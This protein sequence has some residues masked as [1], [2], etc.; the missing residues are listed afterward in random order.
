MKIM[1]NNQK[2]DQILS[3][4][5]VLLE[6]LENS[7]KTKRYMQWQFY[8]TIVLVVLPLLAMAI[9]LPMVMK[10]LG[11]LGSVYMGGLQ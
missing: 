10:S 6:I 1:D 4:E 2:S 3:T 9:A 8:I 11:S 7:R 5:Q